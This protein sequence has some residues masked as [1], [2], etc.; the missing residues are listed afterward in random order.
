VIFLDIDGVLNCKKARNPRD[1]PYIVD[2]KLLRRFKSL[3]RRTRAKRYGIPR[4]GRT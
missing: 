2:P 1:L 4:C 3:L